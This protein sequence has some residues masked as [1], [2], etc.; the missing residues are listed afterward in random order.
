MRIYLDN[1]C[2]NRP[3]DDQSQIKIKLESEAKIFIQAKISNKEIELAWSYILDYENDFNPFE[4]RKE[5][6]KKWKKYAVVDIKET[7]KIIEKARMIM[8]SGIKSKDALHVACSIASKC[9]YFLTTDTR[10]INKLRNL[11]EIAV[12]NP[13][14]FISIKEE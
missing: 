1:C 12:I 4:A 11:E 5:P 8:N 7:G 6:I 10:L 2:F 13:L 14:S 9:D 3:F